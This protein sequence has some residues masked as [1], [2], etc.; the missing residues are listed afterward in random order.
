[1]ENDTLPCSKARS[2]STD[3][4][5]GDGLTGLIDGQH[6]LAAVDRSL[7]DAHLACGDDVQSMAWLA[8]GKEQFAGFESLAHG[9][10][11]QRAQLLRREAGEQR[12]AFEDGDKVYT[13]S[14]HKGILPASEFVYG[15]LERRSVGLERRSG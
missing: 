3:R 13:L 10:G 12:R 4:L 8:L 14:A 1:M 11:S 9:A 7:E 5:V 6:L 15:Y 2:S